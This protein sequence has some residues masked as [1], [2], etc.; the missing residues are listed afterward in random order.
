MDSPFEHSGA[1]PL[2]CGGCG[3]LRCQTIREKL[4]MAEP[5]VYIPSAPHEDMPF[6][7]IVYRWDGTRYIPV[8]HF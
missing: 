8:A 3:C 4:H 2:V 7:T 6:G 1:P 5:E